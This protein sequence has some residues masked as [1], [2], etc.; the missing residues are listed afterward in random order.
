[1][2]L[3]DGDIERVRQQADLVRIAGGLCPGGVR[4]VGREWKGRC[5]WHSPDRNPSFYVRRTHRGESCGCFVC[6]KHTDVFGLV[7]EALGLGFVEAVVWVAREAGVEVGQATRRPGD[8]VG[9]GQRDRGTEGQGAKGEG[10]DSSTKE[11]SDRS[12]GM[13]RFDPFDPSLTRSGRTVEVARAELAE[14]RKR[15][16]AA[17]RKGRRGL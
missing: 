5:P 12:G 9:K 1:M 15:A 11:R 4:K 10:G 7:R 16:A 2:K 13:E 3:A 17:G 6:G 8:Q 14:A